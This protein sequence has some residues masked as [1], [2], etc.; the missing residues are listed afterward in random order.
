MLFFFFFKVIEPFKKPL[1]VPNCCERVN[2][3]VCKVKLE[4]FGFI[5][6]AGHFRK[7]QRFSFIYRLI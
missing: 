7:T 2:L 5:M 6:T 1:K 3:R 4:G